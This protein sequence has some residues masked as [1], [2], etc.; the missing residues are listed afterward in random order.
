MY[1]EVSVYTHIFH[2]PNLRALCEK[3]LRISVTTVKFKVN[4]NRRRRSRSL[5]QVSGLRRRS[6]VHHHVEND[7][8]YLDG[9]HDDPQGNQERK[10]VARGRQGIEKEY[11]RLVHL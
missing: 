7:G 4:F 8:R 11:R 2:Y 3:T 9:S 1:L 5:H 10:P 6:R